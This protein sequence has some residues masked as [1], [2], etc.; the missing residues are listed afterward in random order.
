MTRISMTIA[1][2]LPR[3]PKARRARLAALSAALAGAM[4]IGLLA[5]LAAA[6]GDKRGWSLLTDPRNRAFLI[7]TCR[8]NAPPRPLLPALPGTAGSRRA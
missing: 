1:S 4:L 5:P 6:T 7:C 3:A 8:R 2:L